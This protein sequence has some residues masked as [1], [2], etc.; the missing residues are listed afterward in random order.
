MASGLERS[1][2]YHVKDFLR[3]ALSSP[4]HHACYPGLFLLL[5]QEVCQNKG[6]GHRILGN[7]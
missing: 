4:G 3:I 5:K 2:R 6:G 1:L 7:V